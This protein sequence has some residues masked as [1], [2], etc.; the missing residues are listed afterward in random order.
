MKRSLWAIEMAA[1]VLLLPLLS[2]AS[3][4]AACDEP[5]AL[6]IPDGASASK[7]EMLSI[8]RDM[9]IYQGKVQEYLDCLDA[10][11]IA[12]PDV[13]PEVMLERLNTYNR[14]V[15]KMDEVSRE[16]HRQLDIFNA[17]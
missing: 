7:K 1:L 17:R 9:R 3:A 2:P 5:L 16:V 15:E 11:T 6:A 12:N 13:E 10:Q 14:T 4:W 8:Y